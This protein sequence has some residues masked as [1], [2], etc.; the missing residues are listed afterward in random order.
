MAQ[1]DAKK[2]LARP[3]IFLGPPGAG[4]GTQAKLVATHYG[5]PHLST[6]DMLRENVQLGTALGALA[7][8]IM[9]RGE[10]VPDDLIL[11]MVKERIARADCAQGFVFDGFPRTLAQAK[12]LDSIL[13]G[14]KSGSPAVIYFKVPEEILM[15]RM[16]GRR[17]CKIGFEIYNIYERPPKVEGRCDVDGGEL[18]QRPDD[19]P[20]TIRERLL[21]YRTQTEPLVAYYAS[22][23]TLDEIEADASVPSVTTSVF[24]ALGRLENRL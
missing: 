19:K 15:R 6:G 8:P 12:A 9:E 24:A 10:L 22:K 3:V 20:E 17:M 23:G 11:R 13:E 2:L 14:Q 16:T 4:K 1:A 18:I 7:K 5:V 21:A